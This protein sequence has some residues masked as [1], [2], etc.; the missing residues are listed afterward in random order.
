ME[1]TSLAIH[2]GN[3][4]D[5]AESIYHDIGNVL[6]YVKD[7]QTIALQCERGYVTL[8]VYRSDIIRIIMNHRSKPNITSSP[9][10]Y[11]PSTTD[12]E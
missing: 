9:A 6:S 1:D 4:S 3:H 8:Y 7:K 11:V 12:I 10:L 2:P 5:V